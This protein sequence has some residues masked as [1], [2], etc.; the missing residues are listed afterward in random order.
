MARFFDLLLQYLH[1]FTALPHFVSK[2]KKQNVTSFI[3]QTLVSATLDIESFTLM[4][5]FTNN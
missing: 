3:G 4:P 2:L 1:G 5:V